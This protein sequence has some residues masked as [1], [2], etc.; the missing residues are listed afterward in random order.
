[1]KALTIALVALT[2]LTGCAKADLYHLAIGTVELK[3]E[4]ADT[5]ESRARGLMFRE[6]VAEDQGMLFVFDQSEPRAFYMRNTSVPLSIAYV[7]ERLII[8]GIHEM[9]PFSLESVLSRNPAMYA[10]EVN[11]GAFAQWGISVGD[12]LEFSDELWRRIRK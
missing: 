3:V 5:E 8:R 1:V 12:R 6:S 7:D 10:L 9:E 4:L 2:A 11:Q